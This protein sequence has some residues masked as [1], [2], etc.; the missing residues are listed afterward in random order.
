[1]V[2]EDPDPPRNGRGL[3]HDLRA[4]REDWRALGGEVLH[5]AELETRRN[6]DHL[7]RMIALTV[8]A[9]LL[10]V[11]AWFTVLAALVLAL[12]QSGLSP[13][14]TL[15]LSAAANLLLGLWAAR[16]CGELSRRLGWSATRRALAPLAAGTEP[17]LPGV[18]DRL[19]QDE[20]ESS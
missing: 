19:P 17:D 13:L 1:M 3:F 2:R 16:H 6:G 14:P 7:M 5:L 20:H 11:S 15:L 4:L 10:L 9:A 12:L 18:R 8:A